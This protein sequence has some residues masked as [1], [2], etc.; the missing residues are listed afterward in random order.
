M[1]FWGFAAS[2]IELYIFCALEKRAWEH[3]QSATHEKVPIF[4]TLQKT[5][6]PKFFP[7]KLHAVWK[8]DLYFFVFAVE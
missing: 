7:I 3:F 8:K 1:L 5:R 4:D 6:K 2:G